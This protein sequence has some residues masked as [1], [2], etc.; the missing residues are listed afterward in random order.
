MA[1]PTTPII[2]DFGR[3]SV[4]PNS[5]GPNWENNPFALGQDPYEILNAQLHAST[6]GDCQAAYLPRKIGP[7]YEVYWTVVTKEFGVACGT[8]QALGSGG[9]HNGYELFVE[10]AIPDI[11]RLRRRDFDSP[12]VLGADEFFT[13]NDGDQI[14]FR[15][16][17]SLL[18]VFQNGVE[19]FSRTDSTWLANCYVVCE[20]VGNVTLDLVGGGTIGGPPDSPILDD[21]QR[22]LLGPNWTVD[23]YGWGAAAFT[24]VGGQL[25]AGAGAERLALFNTRTF[26]PDCE[27]YRTVVTKPTSGGY[28]NIGIA[29]KAAGGTSEQ[30]G[31]SLAILPSGGGDSVTLFRQDS[32]SYV[33]LDTAATD[34][35][36]GDV[37]GITRVGNVI[38]GWRNG[39]TLVE[40]T[41]ST[42]PDAGYI[43]MNS[44]SASDAV[45]DLMGGGTLPQVEASLLQPTVRG[46]G[47]A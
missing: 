17:G 8:S 1:F 12:T 26:G 18:T 33:S 21:F 31:Y 43:I 16:E 29:F 7:D 45:Y 10:T 44:Q 35:D 25:V 22:P 30:D 9:A 38:T 32:G 42:Y 4:A 20:S 36:P 47:A 39:A 34:I 46:R 28:A 13:L 5:L 15:R 37:F 3:A 2:D 40:A 11:W 41:D 6:G 23:P 14:G 24:I 19:L 27:A